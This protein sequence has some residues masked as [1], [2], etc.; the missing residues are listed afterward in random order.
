V[1]GSHPPPNPPPPQKLEDHPCQLSSTSYS[2]YLQLPSISGGRFLHPQLEDAPWRGDRDR[3]N[4]TPTS[5]D[6]AYL[7]VVRRRHT[8]T[9]LLHR[10]FAV[11][12]LGGK[13]AF[14]IHFRYFS[15]SN[16]V[17]VPSWIMLWWHPP[18]SLTAGPHVSLDAMQLVNH[19]HNV[20]PRESAK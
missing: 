5:T 4:T 2:T 17:T 14:V 6:C 3:F 18:T 19:C 7:N 13:L 9:E 20:S 16:S 8:R 12:I 11:R 15:Q 1:R 10:K